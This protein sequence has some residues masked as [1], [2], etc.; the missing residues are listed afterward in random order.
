MGT[1]CKVGQSYSKTVEIESNCPVTFEYEIKE[2]K[3]H[4]DIKLTPMSGDILGNQSNPITITYNPTTFTTADAEYQ[5]K[6]S[7]FDFKPQI[8]QILG[9]ATP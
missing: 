9:S 4:P 5:I 3:P 6:T 1:G 7:E 8:I 2:I